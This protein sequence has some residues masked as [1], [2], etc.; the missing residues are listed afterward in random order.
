GVEYLYSE[1]IVHGDLKGTNILVT[2]SRRACIADLGLSSIVSSM[3]IL[4]TH[5]TASPQ[6]G[7]MRWQAPEVLRGD[8]VNH[9]GSDIYAFACVCYE[10]LSGKIPFY[11][12]I[13]PAVMYQVTEKGARP[14][15]PVPWE[16]REVWKGVWRLVEECWKQESETRPTAAEI[17]QRLIDLPQH[18][19]DWDY[20]YTSKFRR[21][22]QLLPS[23]TQIERK[24]S[25]GGSFSFSKEYVL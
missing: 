13:E 11:D 5:S 12:L 9:F 14:E 17:V 24:V 8:S 4:F 18:E 21:S 23:I 15:R 22:L 2:P 10:I 7:T 25:V 1:N 19:M 6:R 3:P 16:G 20:T